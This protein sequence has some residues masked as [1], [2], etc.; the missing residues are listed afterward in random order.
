MLHVYNYMVLGLAI[1]GCTALATYAL[2]ATD[3]PALVAAR[4]RDGLMLTDFGRSVFLTPLKW[5][6]ILAPLA[7][8]FVLTFGIEK[9]RPAVAQVIFW[10][11]AGLVG[12][13]FGGIFLVVTHAPI[14]RI[15]FITAASFGSLSVWGY[16]TRKDLSGLGSFLIMGL[17][18]VLLAGIAALFL[19]SSGL[20]FAGSVVGVLV[21]SGLTSMDAQRLKNEYSYG[22]LEGD[23]AERSAIMGAL[24]LYLN[25]INLFTLLLQLLGHR[26]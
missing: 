9:M 26:D 13:S 25:F 3:D 2:S 4:L 18:G 8:V 7:L 5:V 12:I 1:T 11:Y 19:E 17:V 10:I 22:L 16:C 21:F 24:S 6:V 20:Q 14:V 23:A 15:F